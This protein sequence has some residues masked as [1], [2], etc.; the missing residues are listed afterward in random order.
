MCFQR[1]KLSFPLTAECSYF[2]WPFSGHTAQQHFKTGVHR[3]IGCMS[4]LKPGTWDI[5]SFCFSSELQCSNDITHL[6]RP[7]CGMDLS[8]LG[9]L[10]MGAAEFST[11][12]GQQGKSYVW[13][14][15]RFYYFYSKAVVVLFFFSTTD[16]LRIW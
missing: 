11:S 4:S 7:G 13:T 5:G 9:H 14:M 1:G 10:K 8:S 6:L 3:H 16:M 15:C 2:P 12:T